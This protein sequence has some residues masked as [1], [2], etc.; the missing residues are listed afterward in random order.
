MSDEHTKIFTVAHVPH[1]LA[2]DWLQH[3]R[4]FDVTH[5]GCHFE[6]FADAPHLTLS[7]I[8]ELVRVNPGLPVQEILMRKK[9]S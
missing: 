7:E 4:D 6:V 1:E 3:L 2:N 5:R 9:P 8:V